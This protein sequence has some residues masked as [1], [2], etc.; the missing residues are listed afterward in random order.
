VSPEV[1]GN[2]RRIPR[3]TIII[4]PTLVAILVWS[5]SRSNYRELQL[6][7]G[8]VV[9]GHLKGA[10]SRTA[11]FF[12]VR[13]EDAPAGSAV[14]TLAH[15]HIRD[16]DFAL[17]QL[18]PE[19]LRSLGIDVRRS[20]YGDELFGFVGYGEQNRDGAIEFRFSAGR[21]RAFYAR[22]HVAQQC[23]FEVSWPSRDPLR[24]PASEPRVHSAVD[25]VVRVRDY[26]GH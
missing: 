8:T 25:S 17:R 2:R 13:V 14:H 3:I 4:L 20:D 21:L 1:T 6:S 15:L 22:C 11:E 23:K 19:D 26:S 12:S 18:S 5:L 24:L 10:F 16:R 9:L 7:D